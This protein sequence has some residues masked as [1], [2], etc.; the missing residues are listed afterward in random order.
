MSARIATFALVRSLLGSNGPLA[1][2]LT[3]VS[4]RDADVVI[5][6]DASGTLR[7][8]TIVRAQGG[9]PRRTHRV[10]ASGRGVSFSIDNIAITHGH[11]HGQPSGAPTIDA[12]LDAVAASISVA[13]GSTTLEVGR[14]DVTTRGMPHG[15][16]ATGESRYATSHDP[17]ADAVDGDERRR[18]VG[19]DESERSPRRRRARL[20]RRSASTRSSDAPAV[21]TRE[22]SCARP[23][24][25]RRRSRR[26]PA[27]TSEAHECSA[28][29]I[30]LHVERGGWRHRSFAGSV[31]MQ[32]KRRARSSTS[33]RDAI[34]LAALL[35]EAAPASNL[36]LSGDAVASIHADGSI[37]GDATLELARGTIARVEVPATTFRATVTRDDAT[38]LVVDSTITPHERGAVASVDV[39]VRPKRA[40]LEATFDATASVA[41]LDELTLVGPLT[42][43]SGSVRAHGTFDIGSR[44]VDAAVEAHGAAISHGSAQLGRPHRP[45]ATAASGLDRGPASSIA[46]ATRRTISLSAR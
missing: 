20:R 19:G 27:C 10:D 29:D 1:I 32:A 7:L 31:S 14:V 35:V 18:I 37:L 25:R 46:E 28:L 3:N 23:L 45:S 44:H 16:N 36:A 40:S 13:P 24:A 5:D 9:S 26:P 42:H 43:G 38:G 12:D 8:A 30:R 41:R 22:P 4:L 39:H 6:G 11:V 15:A 2:E 17:G 33:T 34:D 21:V